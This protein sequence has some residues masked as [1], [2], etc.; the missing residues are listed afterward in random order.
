MARRVW[1]SL[2]AASLVVGGVASAGGAREPRQSRSDKARGLVF[3][4]LSEKKNG[5]CAGLFRIELPGSGPACTHGPDP[6]PRGIDVT[7]RRT[8]ADISGATAQIADQL[9]TGGVWC[10]GTG[11]DGS[12]VQAVYAVSSDRADRFAEIAPL[13]RTWAGQ[14]EAVVSDSAAETGGERH[15]RFV[16][17]PDCTLDVAHVVMSPAGDDSISNTVTELKA[18][19]LD[20]AD[21]KYVVWADATVYCG[22]AQMAGGDSPGV[23]NGSNTGPH[24]ARVDSGC[25]GRSDHLSEVHE[26]MHTLGAVQLSAPHSSGGYHCTDE[27]DLMCYRDSSGV[28]MTQACPYAHEWLLD[29]NHDDYFHTSPP[30]GSYLAT[31]WNVATSVFLV[32]GSTSGPPTPSTATTTFSGSLSSKRSTKTF[33]L[34]VG[35]GPASSQLEFSASGGRKGKRGG[36]SGGTPTLRLR[37]IASDGSV[38]LDTSGPSVLVGEA[39]LASGTYTWEVSGTSSVSFSLR[40]THG[41]P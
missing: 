25:W 9:G 20:R 31:H 27:S 37:V 35:Q 10:T 15:I 18:A 12:R 23:T 41:L 16:T 32:G 39:T 5:A 8:V 40:V 21:R 6:A 26:L 19:G 33:T 14:M 7:Q 30:A 13:V 2:L 29:C 1:M 22:I 4:G 38:A 3:S 34:A 24:F 28:T 36:T 11:V 17:R